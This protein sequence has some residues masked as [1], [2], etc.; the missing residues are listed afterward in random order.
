MNHAFPRN[1]KSEYLKAEKGAGIYIF[2]ADGKEYIDGC[3]GALVSN[4]GHCVDEV[5]EAVNQQYKKLEFGHPSRWSFP[6]VEEAAAA[7]AEIAPK[8]LDTV[9]FVSGGSEAVESA[10]KLARQYFYDRDGIYTSKSLT[11]GRWNSFHGN[12][13]GTMAVGGAMSRRRIFSPLFKES[14]KIEATYCYRCPFGLKRE[15]CNTRC[16][17][18]LEE[19]IRRV[20]PQYISSFIAEPIVGSTVGALVPP[21]EYWP[22]VRDICTKYDVLLIA[23]EVMTGCGRTGKGFAV[24]NWNVV[25]DI[26]ATAKGL[27][28]G[29]VPTGGMIASTSIVDTI[30]NTSG[31][32]M[33]GHTYNSNPIAAAAVVAVMRYMKEHKVI[34]NVAR[35]GE[36]LISGVRKIAAENPIIGDVRGKGFICGVEIVRDKD[37]KAPFEKGVGAAGVATK[38]CIN[39]GLII[40]PSGG[41]IDGVEGDNFLLAPPLVTTKEEIDLI[42][43][44]LNKGMSAASKK[45]LK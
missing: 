21:D 37:T 40:Y 32:F 4:L 18:R 30:R 26:I 42:L 24:D 25:P 35:N 20:G 5:I 13:L 41:M 33:H 1:F 12:T 29:Y 3:S 39:A 45:L 17:Y 7:V 8:G 43:E 38:E 14:P 19:E 11:I 23:D 44:R 10:L 31:G 28:A 34:E 9:W 2:D 16:A 27:A 15:S 36:Y 6:I 22:I